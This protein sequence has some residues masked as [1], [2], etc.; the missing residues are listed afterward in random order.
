MEKARIKHEQ[1]CRDEL[2]QPYIFRDKNLFIAE[3]I[4]IFDDFYT[5]AMNKLSCLALSISM[6]HQSMTETTKTLD[7]FMIST[8][9]QPHNAPDVSLDM[10][11]DFTSVEPPTAMVP[12]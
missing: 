1:K 7:H 6:V 9:H 4:L 10:S 12:M 5:K 11:H 8:P 2:E 3:N